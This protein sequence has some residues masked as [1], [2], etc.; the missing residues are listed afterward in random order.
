MDINNEDNLEKLRNAAK[1]PNG[2]LLM[3]FLAQQL[4]A[5]KFEDID[6]KQSVEIV[7]QEFK[8]VLGIKKFISKFISLLTP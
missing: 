7:G 8:T 4:E 5:L 2:K 3:D 6:D 1:S